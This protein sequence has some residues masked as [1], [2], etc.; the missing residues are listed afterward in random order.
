MADFGIGG[1]DI[2]GHA[3]IYLLLCPQ[4]HLLALIIRFYM[5]KFGVFTPARRIVPP[6]SGIKSNYQSASQL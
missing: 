3:S 5:D 4:W 2:G 1:N 6:I